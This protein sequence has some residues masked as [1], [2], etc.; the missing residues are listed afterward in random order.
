[1]RSS[2]LEHW[3]ESRNNYLSIFSYVAI[4]FNHSPT[5]HFHSPQSS[6][7]KSNECLCGQARNACLFIQQGGSLCSQLWSAFKS[8]RK[9]ILNLRLQYSTYLSS[10]KVEQRYKNLPLTHSFWENYYR[11]CFREKKKTMWDPGK[12]GTQLKS[13][14]KRS[15]VRTLCL[16]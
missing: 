13:V 14:K 12:S 8:L 16:H 3:Q 11:M 9:V 5:P 6:Q 10:V 1:M 4:N 2:T 15:W 7:S